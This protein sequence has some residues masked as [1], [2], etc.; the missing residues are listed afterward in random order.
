MTTTVNFTE[1][2]ENT[3]RVVTKSKSVLYDPVANLKKYKVSDFYTENLIASGAI[4]NMRIA[5]LS[6]DNFTNIDN[7]EQH[8]SKIATSAQSNSSTVTE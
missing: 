2:D 3:G 5:S 8:L 1:L 6:A 4:N 7:V